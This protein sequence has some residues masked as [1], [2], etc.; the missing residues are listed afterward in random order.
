MSH[1]GWGS[2]SEAISTKTP[3]ICMPVFGDQFGNARTVASRHIGVQ[4]YDTRSIIYVPKE[5]DL[6]ISDSK[7]KAAVA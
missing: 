4:I 2:V 3:L 7:I 6:E 1:C 5:L